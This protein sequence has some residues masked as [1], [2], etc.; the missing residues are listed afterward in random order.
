MMKKFRDITRKTNSTSYPGKVLVKKYVSMLSRKTIRSQAD[1]QHTC[2]RLT[3]R[4]NIL[5]DDCWD[6][7]AAQD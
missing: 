3:G 7:Y 1:D 5:K 4:K 2:P 6:V